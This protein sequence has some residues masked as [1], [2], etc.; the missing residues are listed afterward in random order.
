MKSNGLVY[1]RIAD[2]FSQLQVP[3]FQDVDDDEVSHAML[4]VF[5]FAGPDLNWLAW[6]A[7][8]VLTRS[9]DAVEMRVVD[10]TVFPFQIKGPSVAYL[11]LSHAAVTLLVSL[12][13]FSPPARIE[14]RLPGSQMEN[15]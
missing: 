8:E 15:R 10:Q 14:A 3:D 7:N 6:L 2:A 1:R 9:G 4:A 5:P 11:E 13:P 12:G